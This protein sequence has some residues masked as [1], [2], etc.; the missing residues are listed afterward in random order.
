MYWTDTH[1]L[2]EGAGAAALA[3]LIQ[4]AEVMRGKRV[5]LIASGG[6]IDL[7]LFRSW[8]G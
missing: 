1:N 8:V 5:A 6:N 7:P 4:E 3:A 2:V